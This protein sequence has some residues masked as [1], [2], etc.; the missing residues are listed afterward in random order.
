M[1][2]Y[3]STTIDEALYNQIPVILFD[4][5]NKYKHIPHAVDFNDLPMNAQTS[6]CYAVSEKEL[7]GSIRWFKDD[8]NVNEIRWNESM[9]ESNFEKLTPL[10][11]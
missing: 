8:C 11:E 10:F 9:N 1:V 7:E 2:S 6:C 4:S 5:D 3:S